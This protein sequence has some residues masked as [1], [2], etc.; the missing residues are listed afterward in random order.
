VRSAAA[1]TT[2]I[3]GMS[4][5][6]DPEAAEEATMRIGKELDLNPGTTT[7]AT[8][9]AVLSRAV[10]AA[11]ARE[12]TGCRTV[13]GTD[14]EVVVVE[15]RAGDLE[16]VQHED[17]DRRGTGLRP[18]TMWSF[19]AAVIDERQR[20]DRCVQNNFANFTP[21]VALLPKKGI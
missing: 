15:T 12:T 9:T 10:R 16:R 14:V 8:L 18:T 17:I 13:L 3:A 2:E 1:E 11:T 7:A 20:P 5:R 4:S 6:P 21:N 19:T